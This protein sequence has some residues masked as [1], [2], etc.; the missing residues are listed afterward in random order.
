[1]IDKVIG[2]KAVYVV[3]GNCGANY[4]EELKR[5]KK[6]LKKIGKTTD[7][8]IVTKAIVFTDDI[9]NKVLEVLRDENKN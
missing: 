6:A 5:L 4:K 2:T 8:V 1:M 7:G 9:D 3:E